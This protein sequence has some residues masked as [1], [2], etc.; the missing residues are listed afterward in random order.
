MGASASSQEK[1][2]TAAALPESLSG[3]VFFITGANCG[4]GYET[5][6]V[7]LARAATVVV[8][9]RTRAKCNTVL[10]SL[11]SGAANGAR[12]YAL[13]LDLASLKSVRACASA[14]RAL[15]LPGLHVLI[16]NAGVMMCPRLDTKDGS[17]MQFGVN[18]VGHF[19]LTA[20]LF[21]TLR[22]SSTP[23]APS[24]VVNLSSSFHARG[25]REGILF[26]NLA[27]DQALPGP[28]Y[29]PSIAYGHSKFANIV[30]TQAL[31]AR[32]RRAAAAAATATATATA[33][34][35]AATA[36]GDGSGSGVTDGEVCHGGG[37]G[38]V[39]CNAVHPGFVKTR[40]TRHR[41]EAMGN[42]VGPLVVGMYKRAMGAL[43]VQQGAL[44]QLYVAASPEAAKVRGQ[45]FEPIARLSEL[46][47]T[48]PEITQNMRDRLWAVSEELAGIKFDI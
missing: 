5:A 1:Q 6:R 22:A 45:F 25:P 41:E 31:D 2:F 14:F 30:F 46:Y 39:I 38:D 16:N 32:A 33:N 11:S 8:T 18:H 12:L 7:L 34:V 10:S 28:A 15:D 9:C 40:L 42:I 47:D 26:D 43:S 24:R 36:V 17:E 21:P 3:R 37:G 19:L 4:L 29:D 27:W 20:L 13:E 44:T 23:E 35:T 48:C